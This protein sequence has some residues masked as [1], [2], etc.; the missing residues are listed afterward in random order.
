MEVV[1]RTKRLAKLLN[2]EREID[3]KYGE[4][5]R[6]IKNRLSQ[7]Q[8]AKNLADLLMLPGNHHA[9]T[10]DRKG[11]FACYL[12]NPLRMIYKPA[13]EPLP[14]TEDNTIDYS[15]VTKIEIIEIIDY[16]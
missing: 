7:M 5:A 3:K 12:K 4:S 13:N 1:F 8:A 9:L 16:H 11:Y 14:L 2:T 6:K 15:R 10:G